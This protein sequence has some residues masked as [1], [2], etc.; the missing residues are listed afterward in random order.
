VT[1][2]A[3]GALPGRRL[4]AIGLLRATLLTAAI[5][6]A[7]YLLPL[8]RLR[9]LPFAIPL[10]GGIA[11][12][13]A[14]SVYQLRAI[15]RAANPGVRAVEALASTVPLFLLLFASIYYL[16]AQSA[17]SNFSEH[18]LTRTDTLYFTL[19]VFTTVGF[20]DITATSQS[21]RILV[22][23]QMVLDL[24]VLGLGVRAFIGAVR[25]SRDQHSPPNPTPERRAP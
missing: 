5:V 6:T 11:I 1:L 8:D 18:P 7:Y 4:I 16:M 23:S 10:T 17:A 24:I 21:A 9:G 20:G 13:T 3:V 22:S 2:E 12:L 25:I 14:V 15:L 19:T